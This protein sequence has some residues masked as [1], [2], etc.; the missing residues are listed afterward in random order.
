MKYGQPVWYIRERYADNR[1]H[2]LYKDP[3]RLTRQAQLWK[4]WETV[5]EQEAHAKRAT[6]EAV[7]RHPHN[8]NEGEIVVVREEFVSDDCTSQKLEAGQVGR[9]SRVDMDAEFVLVYFEG[10]MKRDVGVFSKNYHKLL[11]ELESPVNVCLVTDSAG[12]QMCLAEGDRV[13]V[14]RT[15]RPV[16]GEPLEKGTLGNITKMTSSA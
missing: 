8:F 3:R 14:T 11:R 5:D 7:S 12:A 9:I 6:L 4:V 16:G 2:T 13:K 1:P 10:V 15:V